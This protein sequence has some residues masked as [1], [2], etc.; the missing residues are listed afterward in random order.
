MKTLAL[1]IIAMFIGLNI[2][3]AQTRHHH[4]KRSIKAFMSV[5][6]MADKNKMVEPRVASKPAKIRGHGSKS[7]MMKSAR[8]EKGNRSHTMETRGATPKLKIVPMDARLTKM[9]TTYHRHTVR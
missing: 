4:E 6:K 1:I 5:S 2:S 7:G 9:H 8:V 3:F